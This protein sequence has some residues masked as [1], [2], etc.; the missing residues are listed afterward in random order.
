LDEAVSEGYL[1]ASRAVDVPLKFQ[2]GG[3]KYA[4]LSDEEKERWE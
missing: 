4:D 2:R 3:I 1:V